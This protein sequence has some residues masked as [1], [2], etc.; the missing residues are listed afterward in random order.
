VRK[1]EL[2]GGAPRGTLRTP[3]DAKVHVFVELRPQQ[4][5]ER[6]IRP[7]PALEKGASAR[8]GN[9]VAATV[10]LKDVARLARDPN[11]VSIQL[12]EPLARPTPDIVA[13]KAPK[14]SHSRRRFGSAEKHRD[15]E[16]IL[17]GIIDVGGFDFA[18]PDFLDDEGKT[19]F[20]AIWDQGGTS[21]PPPTGKGPGRFSYGSELLQKDL[22]RAIDE[23]A[24]V[25]LPPHELEP[26]SQMMAGSHG[27]HV[28][29][30]AAGNRGVCPKADIAAVLISLP[31]KDLDSR[32]TFYDSTRIVHA[33]EYLLQLAAERDMPVS[34]NI[35]LGTNGHAHD[36]TSPAA[37][38]IDAALAVPGRCVCVAAG[39]AGQ[40]VP[41]FEGDTGYVMGRIHTSGRLAARELYTDMEWVV[42]G[43]G[44]MDISENELEIWYSPADRFAV[45]I[46]PP[47]GHWIDPVEPQQYIE[48]RQLPDG[49]FISIYNELYHPS[50]GS[51]MIS[52]YL[53]PY[54]SRRGAVGVPAGEWM[55]RL[56]AR[57]VR[58]GRFDGWI[59]RD[60]PR[61][62]GRVGDRETWSFPSFFSERSLVD[63]STVSSLAC[64][65]NILSVANLDEAAERIAVTSSQGPT[66][67]GRRKPE[68]AAPG[69]RI[70]AA[71]GF[72]E[73]D[74]KQ[75]GPWMSMSGTSMASPFV[76]GVAGLML[77]TDR[78]LTAA[79]ISG[80]IQRTARPLA[81]YDFTWRNDAGFGVI[82][83]K[84]CL[85]EAGLAHA[86]K[87]LRR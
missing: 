11:V 83:A 31:T 54:L 73:R 4:R 27:T 21:G 36:A 28:A 18:H 17:I 15:G 76:A 24:K 1:K 43:N 50:N 82:N 44:I 25:G 14:P 26:Q 56:H 59:E 30:I 37:R 32:K 9:L 49:S 63:E 2:P 61:P 22:Q 29:S 6:P 80:I 13:P 7:A 77:A 42:V 75:D 64:G 67:D 84:A 52:I 58:D 78:T 69:T 68:V 87:K 34:I 47:G 57:E 5:T 8:R 81:G 60:D 79:Q 33:V 3:S 35:S 85:A 62:L 23:W 16:G 65:H 66:R 48:N 72:D 39:N 55:V 45:S 46:K 40:E 51:N 86:R 41:A 71:R 53:S 38:W 70:V 12:G 10:A 20:A 19:R 74:E